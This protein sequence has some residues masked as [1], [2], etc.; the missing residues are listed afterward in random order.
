M[1]DLNRHEPLLANLRTR[2]DKFDTGLDGVLRHLFG[3]IEG[4]ERKGNQLDQRIGETQD[5]A[6]CDSARIDGLEA[7]TN[8]DFLDAIDQG[9]TADDEVGKL[10][11]LEALY[12]TIIGRTGPY[13]AVHGMKAATSEEIAR[14][15][16]LRKELGIEE[17]V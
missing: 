17:K 1:P 5:F 12:R 11:E 10:R 7:G 16:E 6:E 2:G 14:A 4:L 15:A 8:D 13:L 3:R 9:D